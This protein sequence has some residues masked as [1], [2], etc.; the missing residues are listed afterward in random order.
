MSDF[1][2]AD[3]P[4]MNKGNVAQ[5]NLRPQNE[6]LVEDITYI[7]NHRIGSLTSRDDELPKAWPH[8]IGLPESRSQAREKNVCSPNV[9]LGR[10]LL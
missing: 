9:S 3:D 6:R 10:D 5:S 7:S 8:V 2:L 4:V 1:R